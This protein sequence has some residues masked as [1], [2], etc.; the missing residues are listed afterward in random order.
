MNASTMFQ[1]RQ[2]ALRVMFATFFM[3]SGVIASSL[4]QADSSTMTALDDA[5]L[6]E[7]AAQQGIAFDLEY[8]INSKANGEV[9]DSS[10][11]PTVGALTGGA[12]CRM[13]YSL[14]D[15]SGMWI[16]A[17]NYRGLIKLTNIRIDAT[18][19]AAAWTS[20]TSGTATGTGGVAAYM[21]PNLCIN[22][23]G[24]TSAS[25]LSSYYN[26]L[27][28]PA[29]QLTSGNWATAKAVSTAAYNTYLN[30]PNYTDFVASLSTKLTAEFDSNCATSSGNT[31]CSTKDGY[32]QNKVPG[33][34]IALRMAS[35]V[36]L[37]PDPDNPPD[38]ITGPYGN[39]PAQV[40]LDGRLQIYGFGY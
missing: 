29:F 9:V 32:L 22:T 37:I 19:L 31:T 12:S 11:C 33:A 5:G 35:G 25:P 13:A 18:T 30:Q 24:C 26:P 17:K 27:S 2:R 1:A 14:A 10:E 7:V 21:N 6:E 40:R 16:V 28:K 15:N 34:P 38:V 23:S 39:A 36:S 8:R 3:A 4:A 20:H